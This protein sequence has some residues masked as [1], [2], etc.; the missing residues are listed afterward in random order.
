[1]DEKA[2]SN[3]INL[4]TEALA[5]MALCAM[6]AEEERDKAVRMSDEW[7]KNYR[8]KDEELK[9]VRQILAAEIQSHEK[10]RAELA[11][12]LEVVSK[13]CDPTPRILPTED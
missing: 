4:L 7:Y 1:M 9:E 5:N 6:R 2:K 3:P 12:A 10:T 8:N 13:L 11:E